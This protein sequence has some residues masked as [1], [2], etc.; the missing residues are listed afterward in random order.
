MNTLTA[1]QKESIRLLL[2]RRREAL[3]AELREDT[4]RLRE[5]SNTADGIPD[6]GDLAAGDLNASLNASALDRDVKELSEVEA[7]LERITG[8]GFGICEECGTTI[9]SARLHAQPSARRCARCQ[10][11]YERAHLDRRGHSL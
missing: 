4:Q 3:I 2:V 1:N 10:E 7:A 9:G 5:E 8:G 11:T 6:V